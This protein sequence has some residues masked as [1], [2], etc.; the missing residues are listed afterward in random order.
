MALGRL[1]GRAKSDAKTKA[2]RENAKKGDVYLVLLR[3]DYEGDTV[4]G[5][6]STQERAD[7]VAGILRDGENFPA[8]KYAVEPVTVDVVPV[9]GNIET[10]QRLKAV[11]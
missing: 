7:E 11:S 10:Q 2:V 1:G 9:E 3:I 5:A 8:F 4:L 6:F